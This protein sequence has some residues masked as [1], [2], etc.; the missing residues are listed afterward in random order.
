MEIC[1]AIDD[2]HCYTLGREPAR[3]IK[4][5]SKSTVLNGRE[6]GPTAHCHCA[7]TASGTTLGNHGLGLFRALCIS[8]IMGIPKVISVL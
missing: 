3:L 2:H 4:S 7:A 5:Y 6:F 1:E 8:H